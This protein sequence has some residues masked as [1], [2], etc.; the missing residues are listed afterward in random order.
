VLFVSVGEDVVRGLVVKWLRNTG[1]VVLRGVSISSLELDVVAVGDVM[2]SRGVVKKSDEVFVY[3]FDVRAITSGKVLKSVIEQ[4]VTRLFAADYS[5]IAV[6]RRATIETSKGKQKAV[7]LP[8]LVQRAASGPL[9]R[10]LGVVAVEP[11]VPRC[12]FTLVYVCLSH[13][14]TS[15]SPTALLIG[16]WGR[17]RLS[18]PTARCSHLV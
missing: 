1:F 13:L 5:Y 18:S 14:G 7:D 11:F 16:L 8:K 17:G 6:P 12:S 4:A 2:M 9:S 15:T 10:R 3:T